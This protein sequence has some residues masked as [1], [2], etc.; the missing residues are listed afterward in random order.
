MEKGRISPDF[1]P[2]A[3]SSRW[4]AI[5]IKGLARGESFE[6]S[7]LSAN[8]EF[9]L[10][11]FARCRITGHSDSPILLTVPVEGGSSVLKGMLPPKEIKLSNH[12]NWRRIHL[13]A[14]EASYGRTPYY[15][16]LMPNLKE[17][18]EGNFQTLRDFNLAIEEA[19]FAF[20]LNNIS[21]DE[22][23]MLLNFSGN[24]LRERGMEISGLIDPDL[25]IIDA[26]MRIGP[27]TLLALPFI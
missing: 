16:Y 9:S 23:S 18:Y 12:G 22:L 1:P 4:H 14:L 2:Y 21:R 7:C 8:E 19:L 10:R 17:I 6:N 20:L 24:S 3:P 5:R 25:S 26:L 15:P 11:D 13:G 27:E